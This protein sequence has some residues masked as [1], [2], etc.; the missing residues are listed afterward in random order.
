MATMMRVAN[1]CV[2]MVAIATPV[3][4]LEKSQHPIFSNLC[5][6]HKKLSFKALRQMVLKL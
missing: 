4:K 6:D 5:K 1:V 2:A 3:N